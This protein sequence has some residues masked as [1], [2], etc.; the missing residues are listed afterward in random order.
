MLQSESFQ[1]Y[2]Y[3]KYTYWYENQACHFAI[4]PYLNK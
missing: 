3:I 1:V 4:V 2:L